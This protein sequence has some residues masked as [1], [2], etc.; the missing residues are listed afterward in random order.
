MQ[1]ILDQIARENQISVEEVQEEIAAAIREGMHCPDLR[2]RQ[3][4]DAISRKQGTPTPEEVIAYLAAQSCP[5]HRTG[6]GQ[7]AVLWTV[8]GAKLPQSRGQAGCPLLSR[9]A[10]RCSRGWSG[11]QIPAGRGRAA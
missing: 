5:S 9:F 11:L 7:A 4:W 10:P 6:Q 8:R 3:A 1:Q 2:V